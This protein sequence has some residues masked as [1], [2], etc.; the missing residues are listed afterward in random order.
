VNCPVRVWLDRPLEH[1]TVVDV[2]SNE[3]LPLFCL[4]D[5]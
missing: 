2:D 1:R 3:A 5:L 4:E